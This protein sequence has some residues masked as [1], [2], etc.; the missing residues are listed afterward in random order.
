[1]IKDERPRAKDSV[2]REELAFIAT[3]TPFKTKQALFLV[4]SIQWFCFNRI[5]ICTT[6]PKETFLTVKTP[7]NKI[8]IFKIHTL[9]W[10]YQ[11]I[12]LIITCFY[13][14]AI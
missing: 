9:Y 11:E 5:L 3:F 12:I 2:T 8:E 1:M 7:V 10:F 6:T 13:I 14:S 4:L